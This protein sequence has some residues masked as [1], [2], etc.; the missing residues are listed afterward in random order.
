MLR[1]VA[2]TDSVFGDVAVW[3]ELTST[4]I[5]FLVG[6]GM[7]TLSA[8]ELQ[9][10]ALIFRSRGE[11]L[12]AT[13]VQPGRVVFEA[14]T[15]EGDALER[16]RIAIKESAEEILHQRRGA[17]N[18]QRKLQEFSQRIED[19]LGPPPKT[20]EPAKD[21]TAPGDDDRSDT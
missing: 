21:T 8:N 1:E 14:F 6:I 13:S 9:K 16:L 20:I 15:P 11:E 7:P 2:T 5:R 19:V 3:P 4:G 17:D 18:R 12:A 10:V